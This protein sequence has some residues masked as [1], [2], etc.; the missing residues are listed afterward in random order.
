VR[1][2]RTANPFVIVEPECG[3]TSLVARLAQHRGVCD[4]PIKERFH[5]SSDI[6]NRLALNRQEH[7]SLVEATRA[8]QVAAG[9][10]SAACLFS[11][12]AAPAMEE[13]VPRPRW[14]AVVEKR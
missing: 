5:F 13:L 9:G 14:A 8:G 7:Q 3:T 12:L 10:S 11:R 2:H 6:V 1:Q 4:R